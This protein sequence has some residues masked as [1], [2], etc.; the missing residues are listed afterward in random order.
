MRRVIGHSCRR[1]LFLPLCCALVAPVAGSQA[2]APPP[3]VPGPWHGRILGQVTVTSNHDNHAANKDD[4]LVVHQH[5]IFVVS[6]NVD[7]QASAGGQLTGS[8]KGQYDQTSWDVNGTN[9]KHGGFSC[10]PPLQGSPFAVTVAGS[11]TGPAGAQ[12]VHVALDLVGAIEKNPSY[13]CQSLH[14][15]ATTTTTV[16]D[17]FGAPGFVVPIGGGAYTLKSSKPSSD[18]A[19]TTDSVFNITV[20]P[21]SLPQNVP[22]APPPPTPTPNGGSG[23]LPDDVKINLVAGGTTAVPFTY[24]VCE[25]A[26]GILAI[27]VLDVGDVVLVPLCAVGVAGIASSAALIAV[28]P[29]DEDAYSIALPRAGS[30]PASPA[31]CKRLPQSLCG[32]VRAAQAQYLT[33]LTRTSG[34]TEAMAI[35]ADRFATAGTYGKQLQQAAIRVEEGQL[36]AA[37]KVQSTAGAALAAAWRAAHIKLALTQ[38]QSTKA[39]AA[40]LALKGIPPSTL[41]RL[42]ADHFGASNADLK[43]LLRK[44]TQKLNIHARAMDLGKLLA[45]PTST[46]ALESE[47][48]GMQLSDLALIVQSFAL[49]GT[50]SAAG[51]ALLDSDLSSAGAATSKQA[52][53][54]LIRKFA[55]DAAA[56]LPPAQASFVS[57]AAGPLEGG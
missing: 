47:Y 52:S 49:S 7:L 17:E 42:R 6:A 5:S 15:N 30:T 44:G 3:P 55:G 36:A 8:G 35:A 56:N 18:G 19:S 50:L 38:P 29:A 1:A 24:S 16:A 45:T 32:R 10:S 12:Q 25:A 46:D 54:P 40:L 34:I 27:P 39:L 28:D 31:H 9:G 13:N 2:A 20:Q 11:I 51:K 48:A 37:L 43:N 4:R 14:I 57:Y 33:A 23:L 26:A 21:G 22:P 53:G 41:K